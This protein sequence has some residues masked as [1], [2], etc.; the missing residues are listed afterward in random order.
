MEFNETIQKV[1]GKVDKEV[2]NKNARIKVIA[3]LNNNGTVTRL[4]E[5]KIKSLFP[6]YG[7]IFE[8]S[9]FNKFKYEIND[10][11]SF[12]VEENSWAQPE[13]DKYKIDSPAPDIQ[14]F[15]LKARKIYGFIKSAYTTNL[16]ALTLDDNSDG[17]FYGLTDKYIIG[18]LKAKNGKIEPAIYHRVSLWDLN[19]DNLITI[20]NTSRL[21]KEPQGTPIILDCKNEKQLFEWFREYLKLIDPAYVEVLDK[22]SNWRKEL[23]TF[24]NTL[25]DE[26]RAVDIIRLKRIDDKFRLIQLTKNDITTYIEH[27][28]NLKEVFLQALEKHKEDYKEEYQ[29]ELE[30]YKNQIEQQKTTLSAEIEVLQTLKEENEVAIQTSAAS[31]EVIKSEINTLQEN[32]SRILQD[33]T[34]I[35]EV[36][37]NHVPQTTNNP[38]LPI[39]SFILEEVKNRN[40]SAIQSS[41]DFEEQLKYQLHTKAFNPVFAQRI[42]EILSY[43]QAILIKDIRIGLAIAESTHNAKYIIQHVEPDWLHF[44]QLWENGLGSI[45][46]SANQSP[47]I[48]HFLLLEDINMSAPECYCRPLFDIINGIRKHIPYSGTPYPPNLKIMATISPFS[49]PEIGLPL[50]KETYEGWGA[51]G[52]VGDIKKITTSIP[53]PEN[54]HLP[55]DFFINNPKEGL[56]K[57]LIKNNIQNELA[58]IFQS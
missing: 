24:F 12:R 55:V 54:K 19:E 3:L 51:I 53:K 30:Q 9:F 29:N 41:E 44:K 20:D 34:I 37:Q 40:F 17:T 15:G 58:T 8:P 31:L 18:K 43:Y 42:R 50:Y 48:H 56:E 33:F 16:N 11:V 25:N 52:F 23:P 4:S 39:N 49:E 21:I 14:T 10:I 7:Y 36:L 45:W 6:P 5:E 2:G 26:R 1:I 22:N 47:H 57:E 13:Q 28:K 35:K 27:S 32:K 46:E 38:T